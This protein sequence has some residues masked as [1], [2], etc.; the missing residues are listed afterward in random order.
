VF[1]GEARD[2]RRETQWSV[3]R[4]ICSMNGLLDWLSKVPI[5]NFGKKKL[6]KLRQEYLL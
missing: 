6:P 2:W 3:V 1:D 5:P 4:V